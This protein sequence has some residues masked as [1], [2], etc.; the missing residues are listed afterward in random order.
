MSHCGSALFE[1]R[2]PRLLRCEAA[3][4]PVQPQ[5]MRAALQHQRVMRC[6]ALT[7][8]GVA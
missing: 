6:G 8:R 5:S 4:R 3:L 7:V 2:E 1:L